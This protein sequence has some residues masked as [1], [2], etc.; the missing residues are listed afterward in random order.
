MEL[1]EKELMAL[2][3]DGTGERKMSDRIYDYDKYND[4]GNPDKGW[5][6]AR[7][8]LEGDKIP[9][10]RRCRTGRQPTATGKFLTTNSLNPFY[11]GA[12]GSSSTD[13][14]FV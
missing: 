6:K 14:N 12:L 4:L 2:R 13:S 1:R 10:P 11:F 8:T 7:P 3:G 9:Y 5:E